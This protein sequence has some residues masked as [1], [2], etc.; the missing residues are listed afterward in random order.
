MRLLLVEDNE[1]LANGVRLALTGA[2][3]AVDLASTCA[4][5]EDLWHVNSY[6][7]VVLDLGLPDKEGTQLLRALRTGQD[8][9]PVLIASARGSTSDRI[10][11]LDCG[12]DD[13][14]VKPLDPAELIARLRALLRRHPAA[15]ASVLEAG[16]VRFDR[17]R[18]ET[19]VGSETLHLTIK[20]SS[21]LEF[22]LVQR[23][24]LVTRTMLL[25][26]CWDDTYEGVSNLIDVHVGRLRR[27]LEQ[28][29]ASCTIATVRGAGFIL[30]ETDFGADRHSNGNC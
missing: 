1:L 19:R 4:A 7:A 22:F 24:Q 16:N 11:A 6:D 27:K 30:D 29:G 12:A 3:F 10:A 21:L 14:M 13:Y 5:A 28:A 17:S 9:T 18:L 15:V 26:H 25:D 23:G 8:A 20:E 2:G